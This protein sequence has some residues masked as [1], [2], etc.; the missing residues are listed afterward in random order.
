MSGPDRRREIADYVLERGEV[1]IDE[2]VSQFGVSRMTIHRHVE[3]LARQGMLRKLHGAVSAQPSSI[4]ESLYRFRET[5]AAEAKHA[6]AV[7]AT[8][9]IDPGQ[10]ILID[11]STTAR[12]LGPLLAAAKPLTVVTNSLGLADAIAG[13]DGIRL[14]MLG[15]DYH[16]TY[17]AFIGHLTETSL[18]GL[19]V[20]TLFCGA[21]AISGTSALIQEAA[22]VRVKI[23]M[24]AAASRAVLLADSSKFGKVALHLLADLGRFDAVITD[25]GLPVA[26][27]ATLV[28]AGV[29]L[30][31]A[32]TP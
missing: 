13:R 12:A 17:D 15:G 18:A 1:R 14:I 23:A 29:R 30:R 10:V 32:P 22:V 2:L 11:D 9:M 16:P 31:I 8:G 27:R 21:S 25:E 26:T 24:M 7:A 6:I 20:N 3:E 5:C 28:A 19:R 4:Y